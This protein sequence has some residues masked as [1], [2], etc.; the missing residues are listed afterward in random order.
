MSPSATDPPGVPPR[1]R[2]RHPR[3][4]DALVALSLLVLTLPTMLLAGRDSQPTPLAGAAIGLGCLVSAVALFLFRRTR[5]TIAFGTAL[6]AA[7]PIAMAGADSISLPMAY[8]IF[9]LAVYDSA[10]RAWIAAGVAACVIAAVSLLI[11]TPWAP[12]VEIEGTSP[13]GA[14]ITFAVIGLLVIVVALLAGLNSGHRRR[15][16]VGLIEH[17]RHL[18]VE[19]DQQAQLAALAERSRIA[20]DVH[21]I[22]SHSLSVIVRLADGAT[23]I[24]DAQPDRAKAAVAQVGE[25]ARGSLNEMRRVIGVLEAAPDESASQAGASFEDLPQLAEVYRGVGLPVT[26]RVLGDA[27]EQPGV[28]RAVFRV[29]QES[30]T[31]ALRHARDPREVEVAVV[32]DDAVTV[33]V[34]DDGTTA[35]DSVAH[36]DRTAGAIGARDVSVG[37]GLVGMRERAALYGGTLDAGP[38]GTHGWVVRWSIPRSER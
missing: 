10:Q 31:N 6:V 2:E 36:T 26:L 37:R 12:R 27:P 25:V 20:R 23:M 22:V 33:T 19:R 30:L 1:F 38:A 29:V 5:P 3:V 32:V 7:A 8:G 14:A 15:Y 24:L 21:D 16:I 11:P 4:V 18:E 9:A 13:T 34:R 17:A 35:P 28:Q